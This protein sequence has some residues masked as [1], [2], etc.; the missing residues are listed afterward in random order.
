[1]PYSFY[2]EHPLPHGSIPQ[3]TAET[4]HTPAK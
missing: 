3:F 2:A 1:L 4:Y